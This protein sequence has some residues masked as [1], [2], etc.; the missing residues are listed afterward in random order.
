MEES[1]SAEIPIEMGE[2]LAPASLA[3][4]SGVPAVVVKSIFFTQS[5]PSSIYPLPFPA[6]LPLGGC[7]QHHIQI[8]TPGGNE[9]LWEQLRLEFY[10][11]QLKQGD[12]E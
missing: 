4:T 11:W 3:L 9:D 1:T 6:D 10:P 12:P 5:S 7:C 2:T 8:Y